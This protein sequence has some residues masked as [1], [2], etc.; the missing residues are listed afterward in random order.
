MKK[1][2]DIE[3]DCANCANKAEAAAAK[4]EG[5]KAVTVN[6]MALKMK[7][8]FEDSADEKKVLKQIRKACQ[9]IDD[10]FELYA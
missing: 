8:E 4:V 7:V 1:T 6:F 2:Y 3:V 5:V 10:D 9:K